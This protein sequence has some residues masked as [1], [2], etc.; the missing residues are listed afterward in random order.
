MVTQLPSKRVLVRN[1]SSSAPTRHL[2]SSKEA[3]TRALSAFN[4]QGKRAKHV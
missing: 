3:C 4:T 2:Q 1:T